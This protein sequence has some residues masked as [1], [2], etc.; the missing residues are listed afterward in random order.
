M[1]SFSTRRPSVRTAEPLI[2]MRVVDVALFV[3]RAGATTPHAIRTGMRQLSRVS[4]ADLF[5]VLTRTSM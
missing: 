3:V 5:T 4:D 1:S 2:F